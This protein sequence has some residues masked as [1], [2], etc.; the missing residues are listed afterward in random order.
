MGTQGKK[1]RNKEEKVTSSPVIKS[2][3]EKFHLTLGLK[4]LSSQASLARNVTSKEKPQGSLASYIV[5]HFIFIPLSPTT[6]AF[7]AA[8][9]R[10]ISKLDLAWLC[11]INSPS[12]T[13]LL[14]II[15][16]LQWISVNDVILSMLSSA[17]YRMLQKSC[18]WSDRDNI[19]DFST[20][21]KFS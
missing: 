11:N 18:L 9:P 16:R 17:G 21:K 5:T 12:H 6:F 13:V 19:W 2:I 15:L 4:Y 8:S 7:L 10:N 1:N 14:T 3:F 20:C